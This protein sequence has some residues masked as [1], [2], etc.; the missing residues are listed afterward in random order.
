MRAALGAVLTVLVLASCAVAVPQSGERDGSTAGAASAPTAAPPAAPADLPAASQL[1]LRSPLVT[2]PPIRRTT[3]VRRTVTVS[4]T[5]RTPAGIPVDGVRVAAYQVSLLCCVAAATSITADGG[6]YTLT[7]LTGRYH[8]AFE[9]DPRTAYGATWFGDVPNTTCPVVAC[10]SLGGLAIRVGGDLID[11]DAELVP[12]SAA[13]P[14]GAPGPRAR[15]S[16][17]RS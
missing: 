6:R 8:V 17:R 5:V 3:E 13:A 11:V 10:A 15:G 14:T 16:M 1:P 2:I 7:L 9:P 4:G 12:A